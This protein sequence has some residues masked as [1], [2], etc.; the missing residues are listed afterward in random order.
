MLVF[1]LQIKMQ[2]K[3][4]MCLKV[5]ATY[6]ILLINQK[7]LFKTKNCKNQINLMTNWSI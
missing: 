2:N 5:F 7:P 3:T 4:R 6:L 1:K